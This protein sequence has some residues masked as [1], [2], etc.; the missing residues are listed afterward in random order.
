VG[1]AAG[2]EK[3]GITILH[4]N[5]M[6]GGSSTVLQQQQQSRIMDVAVDDTTAKLGPIA[7][8][9]GAATLGLM[10]AAA[11]AGVDGV[12][13]HAYMAAETGAEMAAAPNPHGLSADEIGAIMLYTMESDFYPT[14]NRLLRSRDRKALKVYFPYLKL[15][16][17]AR[18]KLPPYTR[19]VWR[20]VKGVDLRAGYPKGKEFYWWAF[21]STTKQIET[22]TSPQFLG[23]TGVRTVFMIEVTSGVDIERYSAFQDEQTEA[24]VV[25][26]PG[27]KLVVVGAMDMGNCLY[28]V[29]LRELSLPPGVQM[30]Q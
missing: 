21:S 16:L 10:D 11:A 17:L 27:T 6:P 19:P 14:L 15:M 1:R 8:V 5:Y 25:L 2:A 18:A 28:Q 22:L 29:H 30:L 9:M 4:H 23:T 3:A 7:G 26:Y 13:A 24:E 12:A 20:G